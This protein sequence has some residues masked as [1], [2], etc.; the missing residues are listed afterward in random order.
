M[1]KY[2]GP[3]LKR[4]RHLGISPAEVGVHKESIRHKEVSRKKQS[5]YCTQLK[6]KQKVKFIY[7][8]LEKQFR[9]YFEKAEKMRGITGENMLI[10]IERRLDN[11]V[12]RLGLAKSRPMARQLVNHGLITVNGKRVDIPSCLVNKGDVIAVKENKMDK[13]VFKEIKEGK[14]LGLPKWLTFDNAS[15]S[16]KVVELPERADAEQNIEEHLIVELYSK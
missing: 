7:G 6:E 1:A 16:G 11:T 13:P 8:L 4:C 9:L 10:L 5:E 2:T 14:T 3:I 15:L 12:Y